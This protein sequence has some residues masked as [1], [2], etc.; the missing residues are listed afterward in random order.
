MPVIYAVK[1]RKATGRVFTTR[2]FGEMSEYRRTKTTMA[3]GENLEILRLT[4]EIFFIFLK[5]RKLG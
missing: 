4:M 3:C 2:R 1:K 5:L